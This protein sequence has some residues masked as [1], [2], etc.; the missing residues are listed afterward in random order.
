MRSVGV[1]DREGGSKKG[2]REGAGEG[3]RGGRGWTLRGDKFTMSERRDVIKVEKE[4]KQ[5]L[6]KV[7]NVLKGQMRKTLRHTRQTDL[8]VSE[9]EPEPEPEPGI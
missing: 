6:L 1:Y 2:S 9:P 3:E 7:K 5:P 8:S 4:V